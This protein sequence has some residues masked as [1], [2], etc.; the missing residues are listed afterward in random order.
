MAHAFKV[1]EEYPSI[2]DLQRRARSRIPYFALEY[3]ECGTGRDE[4]LEVNQKAMRSIRLIPR[5]LA[6]SVEP[7][8]SAVLFGK[9]YTSPIGI[10]PVGMASLIWPGAEKKLAELAAKEKV[11][12]CMST[13]AAEKMETIA[14]AVNGYG[15]FQ[16]YPTRNKEIRNAMIARARRLGFQVLVLTVDVPIPSVRERQKRAGLSVPPKKDLKFWT[17]IASRPAWAISTL[18]RGE[19]RFLTLEDYVPKET[20]QNQSQFFAEELGGTLDWDY[21]EEVRD[22]WNGPLL[23]KGI[24]A[25][26]DAKE[27]V[28]AGANG[29]WVSNHGGRQFDA[30][31]AAIDCIAPVRHAVGEDVPIVFDSG[32]RSGLDV[33]RALFLGA[34][35]VFTGRPF[36]YGIAADPVSGHH[37][38]LTIFNRDLENCMVQTGCRT[39]REI[40]QLSGISK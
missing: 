40:R 26:E 3:L 16:L 9:P 32:V 36:M 14:E 20:M 35:F 24:L 17:R 6:G 25:V 4:T 21:F 11:P 19:P 7:D 38:A 23:L 15:W 30:C 5:F 12:F 1:K 33:M 31:P 37:Q 29:I 2:E 22:L 13:L 28:R 34:D 18:L 10:S 8:I 27:A 39:L